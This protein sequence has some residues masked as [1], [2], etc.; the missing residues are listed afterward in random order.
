MT[1]ERFYP[2]F[3]TWLL[4]GLALLGLSA[5]L[6][7]AL[8]CYR[9]RQ[10]IGWFELLL[11]VSV[12]SAAFTCGYTL[13][14][15]SNRSRPVVVVSDERVEFVSIFAPSIARKS[16]PIEEIVE[17]GEFRHGSLELRTRQGLRLFLPV[18]EVRRSERGAV[19]EAIR[20]RISGT[21]DAQQPA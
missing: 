17:V 12:P 8:T 16:V 20:R 18:V 19:R 11:I 6:L 1:E 2:R 7:A 3:P 14:A 21:S 4:A 5:F 10:E 15:Y 13:H 9:Y